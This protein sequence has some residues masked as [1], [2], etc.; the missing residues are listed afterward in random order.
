MMPQRDRKDRSK[1]ATKKVKVKRREKQYMQQLKLPVA[2]TMLSI[3]VIIF[4]SSFIT[5]DVALPYC[6]QKVLKS[7]NK[8]V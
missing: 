2:T 6:C 1:F 4:F 8:K 3:N 5:T 7:T